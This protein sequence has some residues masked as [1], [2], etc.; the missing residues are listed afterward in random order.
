MDTSFTTSAAA[1]TT[2]TTPTIAASRINASN[3]P[4]IHEDLTLDELRDE[5]RA[6]RL[7]MGNIPKTKDDLLK[8]LIYGSI[9][10]AKSE[11]YKQY[12][13]LLD[14]VVAESAIVPPG[15]P[16]GNHETT[17]A[18]KNQQVLQKRMGKE[19]NA[20]DS[21]RENEVFSQQVLHTRV[22][23]QVHPHALALTSQLKYL[24]QP[25]KAGCN[26]CRQSKRSAHYTCEKCDWDICYDCFKSEN[27]K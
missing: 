15:P 3:L 10:V 7:Y 2:T 6:R 18:S 20:K 21:K 9:H 13:A 24:G 17:K 1:G 19:K 16:Q 27:M 14:R 11:Q 8:H 26:L 5:A 12:L 25:R 23:F 22:F 4:R